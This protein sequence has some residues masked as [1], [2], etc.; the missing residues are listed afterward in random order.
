VASFIMGG[1][2][3]GGD[4]GGGGEGG[5]GCE[6]GGGAGGGGGDGGSGGGGDAKVNEGGVS[7]ASVPSLPA[8]AA[9][10]A[11]WV[12]AMTRES[13]KAVAV[14]STC[15]LSPGGRSTDQSMRASSLVGSHSTPEDGSIG[16]GTA[17]PL[18]SPI[19]CAFIAT[20]AGAAVTF[21]AEAGVAA[22]S[23]QGMTFPAVVRA[24]AANPS[25]S[26]LCP[27]AMIT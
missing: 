5:G 19:T 22:S 15:R 16:K 25:W 2:E 3:G 11:A 8:R 18:G 1:S 24:A 4:V 17:D 9:S 20:V 21:V 26:R 7:G 23:P 6:G 10:M 14:Y 27:Q 12:A 13:S